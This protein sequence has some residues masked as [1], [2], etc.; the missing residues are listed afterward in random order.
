MPHHPCP[1]RRDRS[2]ASR[3]T[4]TS[5][6]ASLV[7]F[8][9]VIASCGATEPGQIDATGARAGITRV[10]P[11]DRKPAPD[12]RG[13]DLDGSPLSL[14]SFKGK[15]VVVNIWGSWCPPCREEQPVL[16]K[17][18]TELKPQGVEFIGIA[19]REGA[20]TSR[21]YTEENDVPYPSISDSGGRLLVGFT[22]S[23]PAVAVPTTYVIDRDGRVAV[24]LLDVATEATVR[25]LVTDVVEES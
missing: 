1:R 25:A 7:L 6:V 12:I 24:R 11:A 15:V 3:R 8:A 5:V 13:D 21:A 16:S 10:E 4:L 9:P 14:A 19:V 22:S 2:G 18:A 23:L 17:L 20:A